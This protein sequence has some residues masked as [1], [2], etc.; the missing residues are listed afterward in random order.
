L[1]LSTSVRCQAIAS[2]SRSSSVASRSSEAP[3]SA[4]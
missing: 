2:P 1:G 4:S 3:P